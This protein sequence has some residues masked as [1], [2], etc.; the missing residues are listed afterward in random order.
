MTMKIIL[1][2]PDDWHVHL[3]EGP[4][5]AAYAQAHGA[6]G[7][8]LA[9]PNTLPPLIS[10]KD[11]KEYC[12]RAEAACP[13]LSVLAAF[14]LMPGMQSQTIADLAA[15]NVIAGKYYPDGATTNSQGG[16][17]SWHQIEE[18]LGAMEA[19]GIV[20]CV[21]GEDPDAPI[22]DR[23]AAFLPVFNQIRRAFPLLKMVLEH[24]S[25]AE[26]VR[27]I[28]E[29][30]G[31][32]AA[33]ITVH[34]LLFSLDDLLGGLMHPH[35][36]CKPVI[37]TL[38]HRQAIEDVVLSGDPRFFFGSDSAPHPKEKKQ[39]DSCPAGVY[40]APVI[41]P[42]LAEFFDRAGALERMEPF[43][44]DFG[45]K[46]YGVPPNSGTVE[47]AKSPWTVPSESEGCIPLM[48]KS[49]LPWKLNKIFTETR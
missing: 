29:D 44:C 17:V 38:V 2:R 7:R 11:I 18:A 27:I 1:P 32:S 24:V 16:I 12:Q 15:A 33:T 30:P 40:S 47:L 35:L 42:A 6:F 8:V 21:H 34:H 31:P 5:M 28:Q 19:N 20:L 43:L 37:K 46:F 23:E 3:R 4:E 22:L 13:G 9:M 48:A 39:S 49:V 36:F 26:G 14:R 41:L 45:R 10:A 25:T